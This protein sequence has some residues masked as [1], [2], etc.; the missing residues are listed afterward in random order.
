MDSALDLETKNGMI[1]ALRLTE[2][3]P[4]RLLRFVNQ[5]GITKLAG[6]PRNS[7]KTLD[8]CMDTYMQSMASRL[9]EPQFWKLSHS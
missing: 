3:S 9:S 4:S 7:G 2:P 6:K 5:G 8:P 1:E